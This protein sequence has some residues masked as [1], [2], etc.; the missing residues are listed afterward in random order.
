VAE[1]TAQKFNPCDQDL[2]LTDF[3]RALLL[4][5]LFLFFVTC[6]LVEASNADKGREVTILVLHSFRTEFPALKSWRSGIESGLEIGAFDS[7]IEFLSLDLDRVEDVDY[8]ENLAAATAKKIGFVKPDLVVPIYDFALDFSIN[9]LVQFYPDIP[10]V[11]T[12]AT[13]TAA[14]KIPAGSN[15]TGVVSEAAIQHTLDIALT[16]HPDTKNVFIVVG[17]HDTDLRFE[18]AVRE[19]YP[20]YKDRLTFAWSEGAPIAE[21]E[22]ILPNLPDQT[23][24]LFL[25]MF[26]DNLGQSY[27]PFEVLERIS[28]AANAPVYGLY[29]SFIGSGVV[30]GQMVALERDGYEA[31]R[32]A[33]RILDGERW[34]GT[35]TRRAGRLPA[36]WMERCRLTFQFWLIGH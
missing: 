20:T 6:P 31:G 18:K 24:V 13:K 12:S 29:D 23:V 10:F 17:K 16:N 32:Q 11:F 34:R 5:L 1:A 15:I 35:G 33:A 30:G 36:S 19:I 25:M 3:M 4:H 26:K 27:I 21:L 2:K 14:S 8:V 7:K 22:G 28:S 9:Y